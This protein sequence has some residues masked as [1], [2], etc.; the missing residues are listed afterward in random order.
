ME[1]EI[2]YLKEKIR[3]LQT[4]NKWREARNKAEQIAVFFIFHHEFIQFFNTE[5][6]KSGAIR[7]LNVLN[8]R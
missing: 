5:K 2:F 1:D 8:E 3:E 7:N 4:Q 6:T